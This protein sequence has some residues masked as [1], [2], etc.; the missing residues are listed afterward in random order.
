VGKE[1]GRAS[2]FKSEGCHC[3][4]SQTNIQHLSCVIPFSN[5]R[6]LWALSTVRWDGGVAQVAEPWVQKAADAGPTSWWGSGLF[7]PSQ[8]SMQTFL[9]RSY[10][11]HMQSETVHTL[12][13]PDIVSHTIVWTH[14]NTAHTRSTL[15]RW[16]VMAQVAREP[17]SRN[18]SHMHIISLLKDRWTISTER[19]VK[20]GM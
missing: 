6:S 7:L 17:E 16:S 1:A 11:H 14:G 10:S 15:V 9:W 19:K 12:K 20:K 8:L 18:R 4:N 13:I 3:F 2:H 5:W